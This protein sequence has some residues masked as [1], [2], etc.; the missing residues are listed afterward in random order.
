MLSKNQQ[1]FLNKTLKKNYNERITY[2]K[3]LDLPFINNCANDLN[4]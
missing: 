1:E 3:I 2:K 4:L